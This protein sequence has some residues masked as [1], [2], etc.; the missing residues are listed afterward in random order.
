MDFRDCWGPGADL[1]KRGDIYLVSP[2]STAGHEQAGKRPVLV[3]SPE[4]FNE[5]AGLPV[6]LPVTGGGTFARM[7][8]FA[9]SLDK[10]GTVTRGIIRCDQPRALDLAGR[11]GKY[12]ET[13][14]EDIMAD[15]LARI[16]AYLR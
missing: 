2:D 16:A 5:V 1:V 7:K 10:C 3:I 11:G 9:V 8:G 4:E 14:P 13:V 12:L 15:V 6:V